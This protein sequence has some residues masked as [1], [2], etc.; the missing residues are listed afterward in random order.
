[1]Q[2]VTDL[3]QLALQLRAISR[4]DG[5]IDA[6][7]VRVIGLDE[8]RVAAG[9][10][11]PRMRE[12]VRTGSHQ[13]LSRFVTAEDVVV[14]AGDGFLVILAEGAPGANQERCRKMR[15]ALLS[16]YLGDESLK[17]LRPEVTARSLSADGFADLIATSLPGKADELPTQETL[18]RSDITEA[19]VF[20]TRDARVVARW[21]CPVR[22]E[23][24]GR[25]LAYDCEY[26]LDG[27]HHRQDFLDLDLAIL[28]YA[29]RRALDPSAGDLAMGFTVHASTLQVRRAREIYFAALASSPA[30][31]RARAMITIAEIER[32]TPLL[33]IS[34]WCC[35]LRTMLAKV[36]LDFHYA[37]HA[38]TSIGSTGAWAAGF[39]LPIYSG[40]QKGARSLRTL[41]QIRF[42]SK[43][44]RGQGL[45]FAVNGFREGE[46]V[47][48]AR[49]AGVEIATSNVLW[50]FS[51]EQPR[52]GCK[53]LEAA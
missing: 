2:P 40:A 20:S 15:E 14:P 29:G 27:L 52:V 38:I 35:T 32:G 17:S 10:K 12:H 3:M 13:I 51:N 44:L 34:E 45:K 39:H 6:A 36:C 43:A 42:W 11:W 1:M 22:H 5:S 7:Q 53:E 23:L 25:R 47:D 26:I 4:D 21:I 49:K 30:A 24:V 16:F 48:E 46:F 31:F 50:P 37:D 18:L 41:E 19:R 33:S 8:I 28:E 9:D